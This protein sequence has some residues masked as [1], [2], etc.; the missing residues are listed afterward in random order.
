MEM[1]DYNAADVDCVPP[2]W[3]FY[4]KLQAGGTLMHLPNKPTH[5]SSY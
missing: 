2:L 5:V 3:K 4:I 1:Q